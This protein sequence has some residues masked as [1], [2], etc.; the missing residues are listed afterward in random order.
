MLVL[1]FC[2]GGS[3]TTVKALITRM[4]CGLVR[5]FPEADPGKTVESFLG[6]QFNLSGSGHQCAAILRFKNQ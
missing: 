1:S 2:P 5:V 6:D 4:L 3:I